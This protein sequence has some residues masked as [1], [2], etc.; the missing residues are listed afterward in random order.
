MYD[1]IFSAYNYLL[2]SNDE[3]DM[4]TETYSDLHLWRI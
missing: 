1:K 4:I 3:R 2:Y